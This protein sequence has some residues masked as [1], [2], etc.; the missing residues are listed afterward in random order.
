MNR[1]R[2]LAAGVV[3]AAVPAAVAAPAAA[4]APVPA[5]V[6][7]AGVGA[8]RGQLKASDVYVA[9][10]Q[11]IT[12]DMQIALQQR[13]DLRRMANNYRSAGMMNEFN[14][15][16]AQLYQVDT[17]LLSLAG[18]QAV[19]QFGRT[20]DPRMLSA[21]LS[22]KYGESIGFRPRSDGKYDL[23][24][25]PNMENEKVLREAINGGDI[26]EEAKLE[27]DPATR[28]ARADIAMF[29]A[30]EEIKGRAGKETA[31]IKAVAD[32]QAAIIKG[33]A[34]KAVELAKQNKLDLKQDATS[35]LWA[36]IKGNEVRIINPAEAQETI[37]TPLGA[38]PRTPT[39]RRVLG[40]NFGQ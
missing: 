17:N 12:Y 24:A 19:Y 32:I 14:Q 25:N 8:T 28:A 40:L 13:E 5:A 37:E 16:R 23:I 9:N 29:A 30:K 18:L 2:D 39:A 31:F 1:L 34:D 7:T 33:E 20:G 36:V 4:A 22:Q 38:I 6:P 27:F 26:V 10:P 3:S 21:A 15:L 11:A 35:G